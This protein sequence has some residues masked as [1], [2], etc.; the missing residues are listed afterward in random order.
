MPA[1]GRTAVA[2]LVPVRTRAKKKG[3]KVQKNRGLTFSFKQD[4]RGSPEQGGIENVAVAYY[5]AEVRSAKHGVIAACKS[6]RMLH[7]ITKGC[8]R[9]IKYEKISIEKS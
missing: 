1:S 9:K 2:R 6:K 8:G 4:C 5:P 7:R 3:E